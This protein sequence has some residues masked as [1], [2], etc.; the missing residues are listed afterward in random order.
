MCT[1]AYILY[2][3]QYID[4]EVLLLS[5]I[6]NLYSVVSTMFELDQVQCN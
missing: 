6:H 4:S 5:L 2:M 1:P 3:V